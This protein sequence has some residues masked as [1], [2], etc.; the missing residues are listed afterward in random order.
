MGRLLPIQAADCNGCCPCSGNYDWQSRRDSCIPSAVPAKPSQLKRRHRALCFDRAFPASAARYRAAVASLGTFADELAA[1]PRTAR[2]QLADTGIAGTAIYYRFSY[3]VARWLAR[4]APGAVSIDWRDIDDTTR[5]D[6]LLALLV[7]A[8]EDDYFDSGYVSSREWIDTARAGA[9]GTDFDWLLAQLG[10]PRARRFW[11]SLYDAADLPLVW[12]LANSAFSVSTNCVAGG[13]PQIRSAGLRRR[14]RKPKQE[15]QRPLAS[16]RRVPERDGNALIDVAMAS[17]AVRHR[18]T[19]HFN[20]ANPREVYLADVG[21]GVAVA[22]FGL[23]PAHRFPLETTMGYLIL[24]NG[25]PI[26]YG[27]SSI[28]FRQV[29]T[30]INIFDEY[31]DSEASYLWVQVMRVYHAL[32]GCTRFIANPYQ[33]GADN[34]EGLQS[35]AF[36][37]YYRLGFRPIVAAVRRLAHAE[38]MKI[39][40]NSKYR[41]DLPTLR[42]LAS[43]DLHLV[44]PGA[45][46]SELFAEPWIDTSS[47]L[48]SRVLG[49]CAANTRS[50]AAN[51][52][53]ANVARDLGIKSLQ[54]WSADE[55]RAFRNIAPFIALTDCRQWAAAERQALRSLLR[56]KGGDCEARYAR[57]LA[58]HVR[59]RTALSRV[60]RRAEQE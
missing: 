7:L 58:N 52:V 30:G 22:V 19:W 10:D 48:A 2:A 44:L 37:F 38:A 28:L 56:A 1:L 6:E 35:G 54:H 46:A 15:I 47:M 43:C 16:L 3:P 4:K 31:R 8:A 14:P 11:A 41:C 27:G 49:A 17:L 34:A 39:R 24:A 59:L 45:A 50:A 55:R 20:F 42:K 18:E 13:R 23:L 25:V 60:C 21:E 5:L 57:L 40:R 33:F 51:R 29:N 9:A 36:W 12:K 53:A 32:T 26:G